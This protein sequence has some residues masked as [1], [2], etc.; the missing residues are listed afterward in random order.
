EQGARFAR[1]AREL[2]EKPGGWNDD[3]PASEDRLDQNG[4]HRAL[5][6]LTPNGVERALLR[7]R[8]ARVVDE[9]DVAAELRREGLPIAR[10]QSARRERAVAEAVIGAAEREHAGATGGEHGRLQRGA[11]RVRAGLRLFSALG[12]VHPSDAKSRSACSVSARTTAGCRC[13]SR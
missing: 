5:S 7:D 10:A 11:H 2:R 4:A 1:G 3:A 6:E 12:D 13:P 9:A 8:I